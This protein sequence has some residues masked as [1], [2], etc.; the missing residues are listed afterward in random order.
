M[1]EKRS[2]P[3]ADKMSALPADPPLYDADAEQRMAF[4]TERRVAG[5]AKLFNVA[6]IFAPI[7]EDPVFE[8]RRRCAQS[9]GEASEQETDQTGGTSIEAKRGNEA[10]I[11]YWDSTGT[12]TEGYAGKVSDADRI[13]AVTNL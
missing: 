8:Y 4:Q 7:T 2:N 9:V 11:H 13:Y 3:K 10:A 5:I 6:H 12:R 1:E